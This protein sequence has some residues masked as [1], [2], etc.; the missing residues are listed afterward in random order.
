MFSLYR[1]LILRNFLSSGAE[2]TPNTHDLLTIAVSPARILEFGHFIMKMLK[3]TDDVNIAS[4][5]NAKEELLIIGVA[6]LRLK[7]MCT[8]T[9]CDMSLV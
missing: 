5:R 2:G 4:K 6:K 7:R 8:L 1:S 3:I 9:S